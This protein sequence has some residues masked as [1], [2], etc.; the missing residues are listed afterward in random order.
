MT[1]APLPSPPGV[2]AQPPVETSGFVFNHTMLR[3]K[4]ITASLD[5]YTRVL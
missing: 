1:L 2:A 5:F 4:D 3:V